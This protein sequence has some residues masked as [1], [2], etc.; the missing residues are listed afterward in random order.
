[1]SCFVQ[2]ATVRCNE[3]KE[4]V[5]SRVLAGGMAFRSGALHAGDIVHEI[6]D[7]TVQGWSIDEVATFMVCV[8]PIRVTNTSG[9]VHT[10]TARADR[11][12][13]IQDLPSSQ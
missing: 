4:I 11:Y 12:S 8:L 9:S 2:G 10:L 5:V 6:N 3:N 13:Q 1:M 7:Y